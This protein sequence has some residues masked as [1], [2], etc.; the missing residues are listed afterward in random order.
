MGKADIQV[1]DDVAQVRHLA[2][3]PLARVDDE[4][5]RVREDDFLTPISFA[6]LARATPSSAERCPV[7]TATSDAGDFENGVRLGANRA[8]MSITIRPCAGGGCL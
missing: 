2:E 7:A 6:R 1:N 4:D 8:V 3:L 5:D